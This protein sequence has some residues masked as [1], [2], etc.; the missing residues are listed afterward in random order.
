MHPIDLLVVHTHPLLVAGIHALV[1]R[2]DHWRIVGESTSAHEALRML[3]HQSVDVVLTE[4][5]LPG[6]SGVA[7][8]GA[9]RRTKADVSLGI[10]GEL[11]PFEQSIALS[12]GVGLFLSPHVTHRDLNA[13]AKRLT[14]HRRGKVQFYHRRSAYDQHAAHAK[15][16]PL[17][18]HVLPYML[19]SNRERDVV[20][21]LSRGT[22]ALQIAKL[23]DISGHTVKQH[24]ASAMRKCTVH[25][26]R[27]LILYAAQRG[28]LDT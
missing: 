4:Q 7:L 19:L 18:A 14:Q 12:H 11:T 27:E 25:T 3:Q 17:R 20:V 5:H 6:I 28:W 15:Q 22:P 23:L 9:I 13:L 10:I 8:C 26:R 24:I 21:M 16:I 1:A 2:L